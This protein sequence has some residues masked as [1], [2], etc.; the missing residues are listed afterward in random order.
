MFKYLILN[1]LKIVYYS[2]IQSH[3]NYGTIGWGRINNCLLQ[4]VNV[5]QK[6]ITTMIYRKNILFS[7]DELYKISNF[8]DVRQ[9]YYLKL[10]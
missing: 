7:N 9:I 6:Y 4:N 10:L 5:I 2:L 8:M 3:L 1:R